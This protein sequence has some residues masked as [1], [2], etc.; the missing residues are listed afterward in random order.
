MTDKFLNVL[1]IVVVVLVVVALGMGGWLLYKRLFYKEP[2]PDAD[3]Q[4]VPKIEIVWWTIWEDANDLK[5]LADAYQTRNPNVTIKIE[6]QEIESQYRDK[7]LQYLSDNTQGNEP[8]IIRI[9]NTWTP[10]FEE[11][12]SP[13]PSSIMPESEYSGRFYDT[14]IEDFR[15]KDNQVYA[16]PLMY[17]G[18]GVYYNKELLHAAGYTV[19]EDTWDDFLAQAQA[20]TRYD[21]EGRI[22]VAGAGIGT[23]DNVDFS[24]DILSLLMLQEG[25]TIVDSTGKT[26][27]ATDSEKK[28]AKAIKFYTDFSTRH[29]IWDR[30]L[31]RDI[32]MF[33]EGRLA[34]MFAPSWRV[35]DIN[36]ALEMAGANLDYDIA[37]AP[38]QP[39]ITGAEINWSTYWAEAV[40]RDSENAEIAWDF[41]KFVSEQEQLRTFYEKCKESREF[42][43]IYPRPDMADEIISEMYVG[44]YIKMAD[45]GRSW[46]MVDK[47]LVS[48][49]FDSFVEEIVIAGGMSI[50]GIQNRLNE[51]AATIDQILSVGN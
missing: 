48:Q 28:V 44:A 29:K 3:G 42:G 37:P 15:G 4:T 1:K 46:R 25:A 43:E 9:H 39:T 12:L 21:E 22:I 2:S 36:D 18:I 19:P 35:F 13:I 50:D 20:M 40:A 49:E 51:K 41:L 16:I 31:P 33:A 10:L 7:V 5:V 23:A 47:D 27:F 24:F 14:A 8:D 17:D 34:M 45:T 6:V 26:N 30:T 38:Q 32:T 11:Y